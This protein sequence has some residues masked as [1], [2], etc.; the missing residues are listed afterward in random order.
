MHLIYTV[1]SYKEYIRYFAAK[2]QKPKTNKIKT[3]NKADQK[4]PVKPS[5]K[6]DAKPV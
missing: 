3:S 4:K 6:L 1:S 5:N 2:A